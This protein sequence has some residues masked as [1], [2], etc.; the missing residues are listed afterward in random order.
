MSD[1][2][3]IFLS[4]GIDGLTSDERTK[5]RYLFKRYIGYTDCDAKIIAMT[6][7]L[8]GN[9]KETAEKEGFIYCT[10]W[11][12]K[13]DVVVVN[14]NKPDSIGTAQEVML[15][16]YLGK[17]IIMICNVANKDKIHPWYREEATTIFYWDDNMEDTISNVVDYV[18]YHYA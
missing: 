13:S 5:W 6:D 11:V 2:L 10:H 8:K 4:G 12:K 1:I 9:T 3:T 18:A 17:P 14:L 16:H 7:F 15:A